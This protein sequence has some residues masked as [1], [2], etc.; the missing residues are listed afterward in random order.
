MILD[1]CL[2]CWQGLQERRG[3]LTVALEF[4]HVPKKISTAIAG[5]HCVRLSVSDDSPG[6]DRAA[7][8]K[9]F[10][11]FH[12]RRATAKKIGLELFQAR[13]VIRAHGGE[14]VAASA[15]GQGLAFHAYL[16]AA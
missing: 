14:L 11:P 9:V 6:L 8:E 15:P 1:L 16:P 5:G 13:E 7:L 3:H 12:T 4:S 2:H 10:D